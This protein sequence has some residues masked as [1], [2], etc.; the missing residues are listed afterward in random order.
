MHIRT[1]LTI[2][3]LA[4]TAS[5]QFSNI[6]PTSANG[7]AGSTVNAFPWGTA[8]TGWPGLRIMCLYDSSHFTAA[9]VPITAPIL[10]TNVRWRANDTASS[11]SGGTYNN[12]TLSLGTAAVDYTAA[13]T[14][15]SSNVG[16]DYTQVFNGTVT[17]LPGTGAGVGVPGPYVVDIQL[18]TPFTYDPTQGDLVVDTNFVTGAWGGGTFSGM[19]VMTTGVLANRIYSSSMY[20]N[21]NGIDTAAPVI[22][23]G[24]VP[25]SGTFATNTTLGQGC[26]RRF[27][28]FYESFPT[29][30]S[31]DMSGNGVTLIPAG[32]SYIVTLGAALLPVGTVQSPPTALVLGDNSEV[33]VPLTTGSFLGLNGPWTALSVI[34]NGVVS[35]AAGNSLAAIPSPN[36]LLNNPQTGFYSQG[37][38]DP[39]PTGGGT[40]WM[41]Q[42]ASV[43]TVT[44]ENVASRNVAASQNTFQMQFFPTG[45]VSIAWGP[46][47]ASG[48]NIV[49]GYS[50][51]GPSA[52]PGSTD[53]SAIA[54]ALVLDTVDVLP[55]TLAGATRPITNTSWNLSVTNVPATGTVGIDVFGISDPNVADLGFLGAPGC[56]ARASLDLLGAWIVTGSTHGYSLQIP[57][58]PALI[59][60][61]VFTQSVV[62]QPGV[63]TLLGGVITSNGIDGEIGDS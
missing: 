10:I 34:S 35:Q 32:G 57:N 41:E 6:V 62:L 16:P 42:S 14:T 17:V 61:H 26:V 45:I 47:A 63:N 28:S 13:S 59:D 58:N 8:A 15:W 33:T 40:V 20:P 31:F 44:W 46:M 7:V 4:A 48:S 60:F 53:L 38:W 25:A 1:L 22:E 51:G 52:S 50:P 23:I 19:D 24:Y 2:G 5:A 29:P 11:W 56:S 18:S 37:D 55:L 49:V 12:A 36:T 9:P 3:V 21:P 43:T 54:G 39:S 27:T 30:A